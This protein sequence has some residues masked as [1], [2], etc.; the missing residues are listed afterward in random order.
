MLEPWEV[1]RVWLAYSTKKNLSVSSSL[2]PIEG[3]IK[4][5]LA[6]PLPPGDLTYLPKSM[7]IL[8][9]VLSR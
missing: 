6:P 2:T 3:F 9:L 7:H 4:G 5:L 1:S 8:Q